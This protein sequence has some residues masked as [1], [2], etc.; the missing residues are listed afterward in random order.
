MRRS[1]I[2]PLVVLSF[3]VLAVVACNYPS[4]VPTPT[5]IPTLAQ[6][7]TLTPT[8]EEAPTLAPVATLANNRATST[9][10]VLSGTYRAPV[11]GQ[12]SVSGNNGS[13]SAA[14]N[15]NGISVAGAF[16]QVPPSDTEAVPLDY[17]TS[18]TGRRIIIDQNGGLTLDGVPYNGN[19][20]HAKQRFMQAR[21]SPD[22]RWLAYIV[23]TPDA[24]RGQLGW[25]ATI[26]DGVWLL[27][28]STPNSTPQFIMRNA[29]DAPYDKPLRVAYNINWASDNDAM[30]ISVKRPGGT[31]SILVGK[32]IHADDVAN[33]LFTVLPY[34]SS[35]WQA[36][37]QG[38]VV[39][40]APG[41]DPAKVVVIG[42]DIG[43]VTLIADGVPLRLWMQDPTRL[44]DGRYAFLAKPS[45]S[46][47]IEGDSSG[48]ALYAMW[49]DQTPA[50]VT[51]L[52][53]GEVVSAA[54]N[55]NRTAL[56]VVLRTAQGIQAKVIGIDGNITDYTTQAR[57]STSV[58]WAR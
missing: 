56:L 9:P 51:P 33:G 13:D 38:F 5:V 1:I 52:L 14:L 42:R 25:Q 32:G 35:A 24:E 7:P 58:H 30:L 47:K 40:T 46:G 20:K 12:P 50:Q 37:S 53:S 18:R 27:D 21:W 57:G 39:A 2:S 22:G 8:V 31:G 45:S 17:D 48:L 43:K 11:A 10:L 6:L 29:Y 4:V 49:P 28:T 54:W 36:D 15:A 16:L 44:A 55:P 3:L 26:D 23:E 19:G 34:V 41:N